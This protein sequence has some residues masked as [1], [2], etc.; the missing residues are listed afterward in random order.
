MPGRNILFLI[1][2]SIYAYN[3][4]IQ[5]IILGVNQIDFSGY[6]DCRSN[7]IK[8]INN[9]IR[10]GIGYPFLLKTPL[11]NLNKSEIWALSDFYNQTSL[12]IHH[13]LTCYFGV[14][15]IGCHKCKACQIRNIGYKKWK[16]NKKFFMQ[17]LRSKIKLN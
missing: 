1:L 11:I 3:N 4:D 7:F 5:D 16:L 6:P 9:S 17:S 2:S 8:S 12:I 14:K 15:G 13:T 10:L